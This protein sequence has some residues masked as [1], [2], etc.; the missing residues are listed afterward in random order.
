MQSM[1][2]PKPNP[3]PVILF[4]RADLL[5]KPEVAALPPALREATVFD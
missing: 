3:W 1:P 2:M 5:E 4:L